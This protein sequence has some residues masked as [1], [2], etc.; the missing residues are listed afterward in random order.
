MK[1]FEKYEVDGKYVNL[2]G[3]SLF[4]DS[5]ATN[6]QNAEGA[7]FD[8]TLFFLNNSYTINNKYDFTIT[9]NLMKND[10]LF[11]YKE[12]QLI[13]SFL[14]ENKTE[15][16]IKNINCTVFELNENECRLK[17]KPDESLKGEIIKGFSFLND[18]NLAIIFKENENKIEVAPSIYYGNRFYNKRK[19]GLSEGKIVAIILSL[20]CSLF[21]FLFVL[22]FTFKR[23]NGK[24]D[25]RPQNEF[26][27]TAL[28]L[29]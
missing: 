1:I 22:I 15:K 8:K 13:I 12:L 16:E 5:F 10:K 18:S 7:Y 29:N 17:C 11:N 21:I 9:G 27:S 14:S 23:K 3:T 6:L 4:A 26:D 25:E 19:K 28:N 2:T 24:A 20:T